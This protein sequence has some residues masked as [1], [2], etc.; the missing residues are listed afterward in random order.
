MFVLG[1]AG[2]KRPGKLEIAN[3]Y[4]ALSSS[5]ICGKYRFRYLKQI[6]GS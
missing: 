6:K 1:V 4:K 3:K 5:P 2:I